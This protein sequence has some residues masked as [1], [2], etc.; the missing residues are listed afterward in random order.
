M[1][2]ITALNNKQQFPVKASLHSL[3]LLLPAALLPTALSAAETKIT[4]LF[5][6]ALYSYQIETTEPDQTDDGTAWELSPGLVFNRQSAN[7][8][9]QLVW[10]HE[11]VAYDD[12]QRDG[13][14]Y[15]EFQFA[16]QI[17]ALNKRL[18]WQLNA[19][20]NYLVRNSR[21]GIFSD[22]ITGAENLSKA[23]SYG[24][25]VRYSN[26]PSAVYLTDIAVQYRKS[27]AATSIVDDSFTNFDTDTYNA[28]LR[29]GTNNR[30]LNFFWLFE[31][32][33]QETERDLGNNISGSLYN[34]AVGVPFA[35]NFSFFGRIGAER[36]DNGSIYDNSFDYFGGGVEYRF[37]AKSRIN[38]TMN[39]SDS[40]AFDQKTE[41][42]TYVAS[43]FLLALSRRTSLEGSFDRR[44]FGRTMRL[45]GKY[46][47]RFLS[48]RL[49]VSE[50]VRTQN[51]FD[52]ELEDLGVFVCP[53]GASDFNACF[54]PPT[55]QY[56]P[57]FGESLQQ[58]SINNAE[59][60]QELVKVRSESI[61]IAYSKN[62]LALNLLFSDSET[63]YVETGAANTNQSASVQASWLLN[64]HNKLL[65]DVTHYNT[66]YI[67]ELRTDKNLS[68]SLSYLRTINTHSTAR[69]AFR[70]LDRDSNQS[71]FDNAE[72]RVWLEY[73]YRF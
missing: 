45:S 68:A 69:L 55:N 64:E 5:K 31:A 32:S 54:K 36:A 33:L 3:L 66:K 63:E 70:R 12:A 53:D 21:L 49:S 61:N 51:L 25:E 38:L 15:N 26:S 27:E 71:E 39:R 62:R 56:V 72:N 23:N 24:T 50:N 10:Q 41:T 35:P 29:L 19:Q 11:S 52:N 60:R 14:S 58:V 57:V 47:L 8:Q 4:P 42:D 6:T 40:N 43:D 67:T 22:K 7:M 46:D 17:T 34:I 37:G 48:V 44:Y 18:S 20:Q 30:G 73:Q 1:A 28:N 2:I 59:L 9:T 13:R 65:F 16:N